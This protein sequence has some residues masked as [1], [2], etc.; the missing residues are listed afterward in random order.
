MLVSACIR[1]DLPT[2]TSIPEGSPVTLTIGFGATTPVEVNVETKAEATRADESRIHDLYVLIF[3]T[4]G[5][6][7]SST[8]GKRSYGRY[9]NYEHRW[10][11][12]TNLKKTTDESEGWYV[13]NKTEGD[14]VDPLTGSTVAK[15]V[16]AVKIAT[17]ALSNCTMVLLANVSNTLI[18]LDGEDPLDKLNSITKLS[19]LRT[20]SVRLE[21]NVVERSDLFLMAGQK[22]GLDMTNMKW[23]DDDSQLDDSSTSIGSNYQVNLSPLDAKVKFRIKAVDGYI[24]DLVT[25]KWSV[26]N[27]P[28]SC[29]LLPENPNDYSIPAVSY[30]FDTTPIFFDGD[31]EGYKTFSFYMLESCLTASNPIPS[32]ELKKSSGYYLREKQEK[33]DAVG[34]YVTNGDWIYAPAKAPYVT[35]SVS[36]SLDENAINAISNLDSWTGDAP[37]GASGEITYTVHLGDFSQTTTQGG[38]TIHAWND[39]NTRRGHFYTY[40]ILLKNATSLFVEVKN[41]SANKTEIEN[42]PGQEGSLLL[43]S[44]GRVNCDAHYEYQMIE[45]KFNQALW[46]RMNDPSAQGY[47][48][49]YHLF[50]WSVSTPFTKNGKPHWVQGQQV[51]NTWV[52][53]HYEV[54]DDE[55]IDY[56]WVKF[57]INKLENGKYSKKRIPYP[58]EGEYNK[59]WNP[60]QAGPV[61]QLLDINQLINYI[62][63]QYS[64]SDNDNERIFDSEGYIRVTAFVD[65]YYYECDPFTGEV[66]PDLWRKFVNA[67]PR[68]MYILSDVQFSRDQQSDLIDASHSIVQQSI[69]TIYNVD[70]P[71]LTSIWGTEHKDEIREKDGWDGWDWGGSGTFDADVKA[72][73]FDNGRLNSAA[74]WGLYPDPG[75]SNRLKWLQFLE[76]DVINSVPELRDGS[77]QDEE[78]DNEPG[79]PSRADYH[80]MV[81]SCLTRNRDNNG[82]HRIDPEEVRWYMASINQLKGMWVGNE[83]LSTSA[84]VYQPWDKVSFPGDWRAHVVSSTC[85]SSTETPKVLNAEEG[86]ATFDYA[87]NLKWLEGYGTPN[88][89]LYEKRRQSVRCVR[90]I[91]TYTVIGSTSDISNAPYDVVPDNY[92]TLETEHDSAHPTV[93]KYDTYVLRFQRLDARSLREFSDTELPFHNE[94]SSNNRVYLELHTQSSASREGTTY[95]D[96]GPGFK[97]NSSNTVDATHPGIDMGEINED[98]TNKGYNDYCPTGYRLPNQKEIAMMSLA[99]PDSY[100]GNNYHVPSRTF[101]SQGHYGSKRDG[102]TVKLGW[103]YSI[104]NIRM[105]DRALPT[106]FNERKNHIS[107]AIRCVRDNDLTGTITGRMSIGRTY[108]LPG[109]TTTIDFNFTSTA[110]A[111]TSGSL[112]VC[113]SDDNGHLVTSSMPLATKPDGLQYRTS[114]PFTVPETLDP[115]AG[116]PPFDMYLHLVLNN[117]KGQ[118]LEQDVYFTVVGVDVICDFDIQPGGS[119]DAGFPIHVHAGTIGTSTINSLKLLWKKQGDNT[120][121]GT[122]YDL[123]TEAAGQLNF[124]K[125]VNFK[126]TTL[127]QTTYFFKLEAYSN[128]PN[129]KVNHATTSAKSMQFLKLNF[130]PNAKGAT[131]NAGFKE[132]TDDWWQTYDNAHAWHESLIASAGIY[133]N[134]E[135]MSVING[136]WREKVTDINFA[137]GDFIETDMD[138]K[139]CVYIKTV[140]GDLTKSP[141][142]DQTI[143][144]DN[145]LSFGKDKVVWSNHQLHLFYPAHT[146]NG[147]QLQYNAVYNGNQSKQVGTVEEDTN[148]SRPLVIRLDKD[149]VTYIKSGTTTLLNWNNN[150]YTGAKNSLLSSKSLYVGAEEGNHMSRA[151]YNF[152]RVV[153]NDLSSPVNDKE[154]GGGFDSNP[155]DGGN[156]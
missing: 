6:S 47:D 63:Y 81:Y 139:Y 117:V 2:Y 136:K 18:S 72:Q 90:N 133:S 8:Y 100:W 28:S 53:G 57:A 23:Y 155:N 93:A 37:H 98:I 135:Q 99:L 91:G 7:S 112:Q 49:D 129:N 4:T 145:I 77:E 88:A 10:N 140:D 36:F 78:Y 70:S 143:G 150:T 156:L 17:T 9:F 110:A 64:L 11:D 19:E 101:F 67:D 24:K 85:P 69:Q 84:R 48:Q 109:E 86:V 71:E 25:Y 52:R 54:D 38:D 107:K 130:R 120:W 31:E 60:G 131:T 65:E 119:E 113:Y 96:S 62:Y 89:A 151:T 149:G 13:R 5:D 55:S 124:E 126:P 51:G 30:S 82:N 1:E 44:G 33:N 125:V 154:N 3:D 116:D 46:T 43:F 21:Q 29:Y 15:T 147:D 141:A 104:K 95:A 97:L 127:E 123:T 26:S 16:G 121:N 74:L 87:L 27:V 39:Y 111:F 106:N 114:Q 102:E 128:T 79:L 146:N 152:V 34:G 61:P 118:K 32:D 122:D 56:R 58:G 153:R 12:M 103:T 144:M 92:Y 14:M 20:L 45:F 76:Y 115:S 80:K 132:W 134:R 148:G 75:E 42:Q 142:K 22:E 59:D 108:L 50:S 138:L 35:F 137:G 68:E 105:P 94:K 73:T 41:Y 83:S 40:D 66:G